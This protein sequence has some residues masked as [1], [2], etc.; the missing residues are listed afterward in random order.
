MKRLGNF[1]KNSYHILQLTLRQKINCN[2]LTGNMMAIYL[3]FHL[4]FDVYIPFFRCITSIISLLSLSSNRIPSADD[5]LPVLIYIVIMVSSNNFL[6]EL[7]DIMKFPEFIL[8]QTSIPVVY[9]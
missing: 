9:N 1:R 8:G 2:V 3:I 4:L 7:D 5:I 6:R